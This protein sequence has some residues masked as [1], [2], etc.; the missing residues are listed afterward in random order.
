MAGLYLHIP[1]CKQAC[2]YCD[3]HFSTRMQSKGAMVAAIIKELKLRQDFLANGSVLQ[4]IY[5]GG[6]T[7]SLLTSGELE[8][9]WV[10]VHQQFKVAEEAEITLEANPDDLGREYLAFL[11]D[12]GINRLSIG[13]QSFLQE[14]LTWMNRTHT[15]AQALTCVKDA[16]AI[17]FSAIS[18]DLIFG[19]PYTDRTTWS[20]QVQQAAQ[21]GVPHLSIYALTV[22]EKT[23]LHHWVN[24]DSFSLPE[25]QV[26]KTQFLD[27]HEYLTSEGYDHYEL[28]NYALPGSYAKHNSAY[29]SGIP[30]LGLGPSAHSFNGT[31]RFSNIA[32]NARYMQQVAEGISPVQLSE[33]LTPRDLYNEYIMTQLRTIKGISVSYLQQQFGKLVE[34]EFGRQLEK[35]EAMGLMEKREDNWVLTAE[36]W[37]VSDG[38]IRK[39]FD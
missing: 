39:L 19:T 31:H 26:A 1:Y 38:I 22:E 20:Q 24:K 32:N 12:L 17:G 5:L 34:V 18:I 25:D 14:E 33:K 13:I 21:L 16:Q 9:L 11:K 10:A 15:A 35:W 23:A 37:W 6:G 3:F 7:P 30:Y 4:S 8:E 2:S 36:G 29:W 27:A 28:S